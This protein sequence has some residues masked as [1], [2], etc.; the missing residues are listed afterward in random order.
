MTQYLGRQQEMSQGGYLPKLP[1]D[2]EATT[3]TLVLDLDETLIHFDQDTGTN[4]Q[5]DDPSID[6]SQVRGVNDLIHFRPYLS[7]FLSEMSQHYE[8][9]IFTAALQDYADYILDQIDPDS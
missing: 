5:L 1:R 9:V 8:V 3:Y 4:M 7:E 6:S 2:K